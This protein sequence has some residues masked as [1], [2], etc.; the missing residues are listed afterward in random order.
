MS[1]VQVITTKYGVLCKNKRM[2]WFHAKQAPTSG[3]RGYFL[4]E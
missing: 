4:E 1:F 3:V 2:L